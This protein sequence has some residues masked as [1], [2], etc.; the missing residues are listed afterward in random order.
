VDTNG[1]L[2]ISSGLI[3]GSEQRAGGGI[4][5]NSATNG[6][7]TERIEIEYSFTIGGQSSSSYA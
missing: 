7:G 1:L 6:G 4:G 3:D 2:Q 5:G